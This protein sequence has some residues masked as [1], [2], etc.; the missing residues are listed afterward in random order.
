MDL[1][2]RTGLTTGVL[3]ITATVA[4]LAGTAIEQPVLQGT[5]HLTRIS[6]N[7][8]LVSA[9]ALLEFIAAGTSVGIAISLYPVLRSWSSSLALGSV[10]FRTIEAVMYTAGAVSLLSFLAVGQR[11][12]NASIADRPSI[13]LIGDS[14][15]SARQEF[16]LAG[17]FAFSLGALMYYYVFYQSRLIPRWLSVW[18]IAA[19]LGILVACL[20]ALFSGN[21]VTTYAILI[22]PIAVQEMVLAVWLIARGFSSSAVQRET[23]SVISAA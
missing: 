5:N 18:G 2:R 3:F 16:I 9:G 22:L 21:S 10:V 17:V 15:L 6:G 4:S 19:V 12:T 7:A 20:S 8:N 23:A 11:F 1:N 13:Q 14:L